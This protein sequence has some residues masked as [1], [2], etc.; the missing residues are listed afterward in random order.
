[1]WKG[2]PSDTEILI[3]HG[4]PYKIGDLVY[5]LKENV[6]VGCQVLLEHVAQRIKPI[7][8]IFGHIHEGYGVSLFKNIKITKQGQTTYINAS[9]CTVEYRPSNS[10]I[11]FTLPR[12]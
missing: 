7:Y 5:H 2:I 3:T 10:P 8:H 9:I 11:V 6:N 4:P 1:M 12:R